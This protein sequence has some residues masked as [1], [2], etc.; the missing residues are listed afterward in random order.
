MKTSK[1]TE[2]QIAFALRQAEAGT[3]VEQVCREPGVSEAT[4]YRWKRRSGGM[5]VAEVGRLRQPANEPFLRAIEISDRRYDRRE[6]D[7][8]A[9]TASGRPEPH[10]PALEAH[11]GF[12]DDRQGIQC[13]SVRAGDA[14]PHP[15]H[16]SLVRRSNTSFSGPVKRPTTIEAG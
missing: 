10:S 3:P 11:D 6:R 2:E 7:S 12:A 14:D 4:F 9:T 16:E 8:G 15:V 13:R 5:G 1:F